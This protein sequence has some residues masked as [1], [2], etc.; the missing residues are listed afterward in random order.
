M[1]TQKKLKSCQSA[2]LEK[3]GREVSI[4]G[5]G[6]VTVMGL[7]AK[8]AAKVVEDSLERGVNYFDVA[9]FLW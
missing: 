8:L 9:P 7:Q 4:I 1:G 5:L 3:T 6:G 2:S